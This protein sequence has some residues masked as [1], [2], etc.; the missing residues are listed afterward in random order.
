M[1]LEVL[2]HILVVPE[3][4]FDGGTLGKSFGIDLVMWLSFHARLQQWCLHSAITVGCKTILVKCGE[5]GVN[6]VSQD[7]LTD[8]IITNFLNYIPTLNAFGGNNS[9]WFILYNDM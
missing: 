3:D 5:P 9:K 1:I 8:I 7:T 4:C 2:V 6:I